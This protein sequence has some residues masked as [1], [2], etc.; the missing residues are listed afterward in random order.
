MEYLGGSMLL[1]SSHMLEAE[2][3]SAFARERIPF[4]VRELEHIRWV[5]TER[6]L[7]AEMSTILSHRLLR[8]ADLWHVAHAMYLK[9][10][11]GDIEFATLDI[12]QRNAAADVGL[13][14]TTFA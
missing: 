3:R 7:G 11:I 6:R 2:V 4:D 10:T 1:Y 14:V 8:G 5:I 13:R 12:A 9:Q